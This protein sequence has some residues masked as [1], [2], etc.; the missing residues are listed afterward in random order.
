MGK[1]ISLFSGYSQQ[2]NRTTNYCLLIL[3]MLYEENPKFLAEALGSL[4]DPNIGH[5]IGVKFRQQE[6]RKH[7]IP[8]GLILQEA[9]TIYIETKN[10]DWFYD[11]QLE[12]HLQ[13]LDSENAGVKILIALSKFESIENRFEQIKSIC[14]EKYRDSIFF[15]QVNFEVFIQALEGLEQLPKNLSDAISDFRDYLNEQRLLTTWE[16]WLDVVNCAA[17]PE[18]VLEGKVY[19]CPAEGGS[20]TH[21]RCKY[22]GMYRN[23][24]VE[25]IALIEAVID[26]LSEDERKLKW[27]NVKTSEEE[28]IKRAMEMHNKYRSGKYPLRVFLLGEKYETNFSKDTKYGMWGTKKY[29]DVSS[30]NPESASDLAKK[31]DGIPWSQLSG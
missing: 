10:Y 17:L 12:N 18:E 7:S 4:I 27:K 31:L 28:L 2:E 3:K 16:R 24:R 20:Y 6:K 29:F 25:N 13:A 1:A 19:I 14:K 5:Y 23:K 22:F 30:L 21:S 26:L 9:C 11:S 8:D 15:A